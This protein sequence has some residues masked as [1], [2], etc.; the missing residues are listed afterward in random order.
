MLLRARFPNLLTRIF[1]CAPR[2][3]QIV[4]DSELQDAAA[5]S[6]EFDQ[7]IR[8]ATLHAS[9]S[10]VVP[11][12]FLRELDPIDDAV[13]AGSMAG[14]PFRRFDVFNILSARFPDL[15]I[16]D[17]ESDFDNGQC[18][19][20]VEREISDA[21]KAGLISFADSLGSP[22]PFDIRVASGP[23]M[24]PT[25]PGEDPMFVIASRHRPHAPSF[26]RQDEAFWFDNLDA[27]AQ[28]VFGRDDFPGMR[29]Q[30]S[31]CYVDATSG[32][33]INLR[34][35]LMLYDVV[36]L[37]PPL[38]HEQQPFLDDQALTR[39]DLLDMVGAGRLRLV[40]NQP[41]E[42]IDLNLLA[43]A[44]ER[45]EQAIIGRRMSAAMLLASVV[46]TAKDYRLADQSFF[47][48]IKA[49]A[50]ALAPLL[51]LEP[52]DTLQSLLWPLA[53]RREGLLRL[54][55]RGSKGAPAM[56]V[57]STLASRL[58]ALHSVDLSLET[59]VLSERVHIAHA[60]GATVMPATDEPEGY[61]TL[62]AGI[63]EEL[64]FYAGFNRRIA[65]SWA[66]NQERRARGATIVPPIAMFEFDITIPIA[67]L[68][69]DTALGST[70]GAGRA[71]V[72]RLADLPDELRDQEIERLK[73]RLRGKGRWHPKKLISF[74][75]A[76]TGLAIASLFGSF[77]YPPLAGI[78]NMVAP[79][80]ES[81]RRQPGI[82]QALV[83]LRED[84][85]AIFGGN[86]DIAFL[87]RIDRVA[88][89]KTTRAS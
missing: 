43:A 62:M 85:Q 50:T 30:A 29:D 42:R 56:T 36:F 18:A 69:A 70:R 24:A 74:D 84:T 64:N 79:L 48:P 10:N 80:I 2:R 76:D 44:N 19:V 73:A 71:L 54:L 25:L 58:Q 3:Y 53:A 68:L 78:G 9:L 20:F 22:L 40:M 16:V 1:E 65:A 7:K 32:S 34:Q 14:L 67:E 77:V 83:R 23:V 37:S 12:T 49:L 33:H 4:F 26:V 31:R 38:A 87:S 41:E 8:F 47:A 60:L 81:L 27:V 46:D 82:D 52:A 13:V 11:P 88:S 59:S 15:A 39:D 6:H 72:T 75:N 55:D 28:G 5:I 63:G 57:A 86:Q 51:T 45:S 21:D 89:F 66:D 61:Q 17:V 35:L